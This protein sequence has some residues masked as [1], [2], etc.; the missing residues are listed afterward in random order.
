MQKH[1]DKI[2]L[3]GLALRHGTAY[4]DSLAV[5]VPAI[6]M[7]GEPYVVVDQPLMVRLN[8]SRTR[9]GYVMRVRLDTT[10]RGPC[11]RCTDPIDVPVLIDQNEVHEPEL[12]EEL[13]SDYIDDEQL[14]DLAG[15]VCD[16]VSL[17]LPA[18][19]SG[20]LEDDGG[21]SYCLRDKSAL[22]EMGIVDQSQIEHKDPRWAKLDD[23][24]LESS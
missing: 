17:S 20:P 22:A 13:G 9:T 19:I 23:L 1:V 8:V 5:S 7:A 24:K 6:V 12:A 4:G 10:V 16:A 21:C 18:T 11:M 2:D 14:F 3:P 15:F